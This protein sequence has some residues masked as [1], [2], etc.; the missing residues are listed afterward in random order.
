[1]QFMY[2]LYIAGVCTFIGVQIHLKM[3]KL[4]SDFSPYLL[5]FAFD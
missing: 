4:R 5:I 3:L 1:M 2:T